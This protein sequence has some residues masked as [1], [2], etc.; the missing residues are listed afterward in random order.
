LIICKNQPIIFNGISRNVSGIYKDTLLNSQGCD[1]FLYLH[2]T[3]KDTTKKDSFRIICKNQFVVFNGQTLNTTGIYKDTL[4][5]SQNCDSF[6]YLHLT[7]NDTIRTI[8]FDTICQN[9]TK[10][11]GLKTINISGTYFD[12]LKRA[13]GCD[14][15]VTLHLFVK[16]TTKKDS[17]LTTC[18]NQP[19]VFNGISRNISGIYRNTLINSKGCDSFVYLHLTV[20][21]T[22]KKDSFLSICK[23]QPIVFNGMSRNVS[24]IYKDTLLNSKGCDSFLYLHLTVNDTTKKDSFRIICKNQFVVFNG[25]TLNTTGIYKDTLIN[26]KGCDSFIYLHL[27]VNDTTKKD[28]FLITC[29]NQ[30]IFFNGILRNT[31]GLY[32]D[33]LVN[34][35]GCDSFVYL[36]LTVND[37]TKKDSFL[38]TCKNQSVIF[39]GM[40]RNTS[41]VYRDTLLNSKGCDSFLYL[42]LTV[43]DTTKFDTSILI[44]NNDSIFFNNK[45]L[46]KSGIYKDTFINTNGC[47]SF[48][49]LSFTSI[50]LEYTFFDT[51][52]E[53]Q[54]SDGYNK[55][56]IY[57]DSF[58]NGNIFGCDSV[59]I[60]NL[61]VENVKSFNLKQRICE[62]DTFEGYFL[63]NTYIDTLPANAVERCYQIRTIELEVI[64]RKII[65]SSIICQGEKYRGFYSNNK[66]D[67]ISG[68]KI[69]H[70]DTIIDLEGCTRFIELYLTV[71]D[72]G[73]KYKRI[74]LCD[75]DSY[76]GIK[77]SKV[78][79]DT[80]VA[81]NG[82]PFYDVLE[83]VK[84]PK[85]EINLNDT[86]ICEDKFN[87]PIRMGTDRVFKFYTWNTGETTPFI[88]VSKPGLYYLKVMNQNGCIG[89]DSMYVN[90]LENP[91]YEKDIQFDEVEERY[92]I[93]IETDTFLNQIFWKTS[94]LIL[95][96]T[97]FYQEI[98]FKNQDSIWLYF[99]IENEFNCKIYDS[100][101]ILK[102]DSLSGFISFPSAFS[103][104]G[105]F[106]NDKFGPIAKNVKRIKW[107]IFNRWGEVV[108]LSES[109][110]NWWNG[111]FK[112]EAC[113]N[114]LYI[115][116]CEVTFNNGKTE[117]LKGEVYLMR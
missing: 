50:P 68:M 113:M 115:W 87:L 25:Q 60:L 107:S 109:E 21:D 18:K 57:R 71:L 97:C 44:C 84:E 12:T 24:G 88:N 3:V 48:I 46:T 95:C 7:V 55:T 1:S 76:L 70:L 108:F 79:R 72:T 51:I 17:F 35:K 100:I 103:P 116:T 45:W 94:N 101:Q 82:C 56:G 58:S 73:Y 33:T 5:N 23:N 89:Y 16:D 86:S 36:N 110:T 102:I 111:T 99:E 42:H 43:K 53:Y 77:E 20:K 49:Y 85:I 117:K 78:F 41:G 64:E 26:A 30:P 52:C 29:K 96:Q 19:I 47:D 105:D 69:P 92:E 10:I 31:S 83:I 2:L 80:L 6:L 54:F 27:N 74:D 66:I 91:F 28:S 14:S 62:G 40:S 90:S 81:N 9:Q 93:L 65:D 63:P 38:I 15:F 114:N 112:N 104:N 37:T 98:K 39:N 11:F 13:S 8:L 75:G 34:S 59:R 32:K 67:S 4:V 61:E 106:R 22:T